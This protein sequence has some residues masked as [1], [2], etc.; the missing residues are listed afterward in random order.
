MV[1]NQVITG[2]MCLAYVFVK[3]MPA[4]SNILSSTYVITEFQHVFI[5]VLFKDI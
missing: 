3:Y 4:T 5:L 2:E 1:F